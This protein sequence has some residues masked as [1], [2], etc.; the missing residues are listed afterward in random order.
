MST[1]LYPSLCTPPV[2]E[3]D[4]S[5]PKSDPNVNLSYPPANSIVNKLTS[6]GLSVAMEKAPTTKQGWVV[7]PGLSVTRTLK[8]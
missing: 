8:H 5:P 7:P 2:V 3:L 6:M 1:P 4:A